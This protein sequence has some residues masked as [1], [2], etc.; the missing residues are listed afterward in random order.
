MCSEVSSLA[1]EKVTPTSFGSPTIMESTT[2]YYLLLTT[3]YSL[4]T[5]MVTSTSFGSPTIMELT[6]LSML[7][8]RRVAQRGRSARTARKEVEL[9]VGKKTGSL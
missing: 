4:L 6:S 2:T 7:G 1:G 5:K 3:Y 8:Q 9:S